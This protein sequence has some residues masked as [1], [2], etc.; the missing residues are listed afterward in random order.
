MCAFD[1]IQLE[2]R[3]IKKKT[4]ENLIDKYAQRYPN[5]TNDTHDNSKTNTQNKYRKLLRTKSKILKSM[6][7]MTSMA[8]YSFFYID[9]YK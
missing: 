9:K 7:L 8:P 1:D 2:Q 5:Q 6:W 3:Y 4:N